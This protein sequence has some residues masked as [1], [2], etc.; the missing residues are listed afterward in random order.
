MTT[1]VY[2]EPQYA[3]TYSRL[4]LVIFCLTICKN[5]DTNS[6]MTYVLL[7][8]WPFYDLSSRAKCQTW[9]NGKVLILWGW[10]E[11]GDSICEGVHT[12]KPFLESEGKAIRDQGRRKVNVGQVWQ[13]AGKGR[14]LVEWFN[15][16]HLRFFFCNINYL[17]AC[18]KHQGQ[19]KSKSCR[20][21]LIVV[22]GGACDLSGSQGQGLVALPPGS[23]G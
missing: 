13:E 7:S 6:K 1:R 23:F 4:V 2:Q 14:W 18:W 12:F 5:R 8:S 16:A 21:V 20:L 19:H 22:L 17:H 9:A 11:P 10:W 15:C 3:V